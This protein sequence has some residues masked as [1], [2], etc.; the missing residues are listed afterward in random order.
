MKKYDIY[1]IGN[2]LVDLVFEVEDEFEIN[3]SVA[4]KAKK[5]LKAY[6]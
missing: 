2:A 4:A 6:S 3:A 1:G 5:M